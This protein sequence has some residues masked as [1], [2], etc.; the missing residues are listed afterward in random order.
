MQTRTIK[1]AGIGWPGDKPGFACVLELSGNVVYLRTEIEGNILSDLIDACMVE[2]QRQPRDIVGFVGRPIPAVMSFVSDYNADELHTFF[3]FGA[4]PNVEKTGDIYYHWS[5]IQ[6][7]LLAD[8]KKL[9]LIPE[10]SGPCML[11]SYLQEPPNTG[12]QK[13]TDMEYPAIAALGYSLSWLDEEKRSMSEQYV[14]PQ[15][16]HRSNSTGY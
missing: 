15:N 5:M 11:R 6:S 10:E 2:F 13:M 4:A 12:I 16:D 8:K 7:Y 9:W 1:I 14:A 3:N